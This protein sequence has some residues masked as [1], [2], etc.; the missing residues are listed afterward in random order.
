MSLVQRTGVLF[1]LILT[2][3]VCHIYYILYFADSVQELKPPSFLRIN[4]IPVEL[5]PTANTNPPKTVSNVTTNPLKTLFKSTINAIET[6]GANIVNQG[7]IDV[8]VKIHD[9]ESALAK[10]GLL[11][12]YK[13]C[14]EFYKPLDKVDYGDG[15]CEHHKR[16]Q[17]KDLMEKWKN[18]SET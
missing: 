9:H 11:P 12:N 3:G 15:T 7:A 14:E 17:Y 16:S 13:H 8:S 2:I 6:G 4:I 10:Q 1:G 5:H 18:I